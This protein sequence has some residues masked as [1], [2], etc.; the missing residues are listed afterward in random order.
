MDETCDFYQFENIKADNF[1]LCDETFIQCN[2]CIHTECTRK[3]KIL[4]KI[5]FDDSKIFANRILND[6]YFNEEKK[7]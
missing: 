5:R 2:I 4:T 1:S 7:N 3:S 6:S